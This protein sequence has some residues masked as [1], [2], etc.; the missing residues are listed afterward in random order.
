LRASNN[1]LYVVGAHLHAI[2]KDGRLVWRVAIPET[3]DQGSLS[4]NEQLLYIQSGHYLY[5]YE[6][7]SGR[8]LW[9]L[10]NECEYAFCKP[11][12][13]TDGS[14][15]MKWTVSKTKVAPGQPFAGLRIIDRK[16]KVVAERNQ[17]D[18]LFDYFVPVGTN[19]V[20]IEDDHD[21]EAI[22]AQAKLLWAKEPSWQSTWH[23]AAYPEKPVVS[24][25]ATPAS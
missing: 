8:R 23:L 24:T 19:I 22:D 12:P 9:R 16:G 13:L 14:V 5:A 6:T 17:K 15:A 25:H 11:Q 10:A 18:S 4:S 2:D 21:L 20:V 7:K 1:M 3:M